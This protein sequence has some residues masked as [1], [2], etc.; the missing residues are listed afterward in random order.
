M[1]TGEE[2]IST[3]ANPR[4][5]SVQIAGAESFDTRKYPLYC[6]HYAVIDDGRALADVPNNSIFGGAGYA[7]IVDSAYTTADEFKAYLA[8]QYASGTP[9]TVWYVLNTPTTESVTCPTIT[10]AAGS[11]TL[12]IGTTLAPSGVS[13]TGKIKEV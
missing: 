13:I 8:Q 4:R 11:N 6:T 1:L 10:P 12:S 9:V 3:S 7:Y 2:N 5:F